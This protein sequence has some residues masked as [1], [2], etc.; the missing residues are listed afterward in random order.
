MKHARAVAFFLLAATVCRA[1]GDL[2][3]LAARLLVTPSR[4]P[5]E[6]ASVV[7]P[8]RDVGQTVWALQLAGRPQEAQAVAEFALRALDGAKNA[9]RPVGSLPPQVNSRGESSLPRCYVDAQ[10]VS[11]ALEA[12]WRL[13]SAMPAPARNAWLQEWWPRIAAAAEFVVGWTRGPRGEPY[14]AYDPGVNHDMGGAFESPG[15]LLGVVCAQNLAQLAGQ[16]VPE[17]WQQRREALEILVRTTDFTDATRATRPPWGLPN[18]RG[19]LPE[20]HPL[21]LAPTNSGDTIQS[22][23]IAAWPANRD[24]AQEIIALK[25]TPPTSSPPAETAGAPV[26]GDAP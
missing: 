7:I 2:G 9:G 3:S 15:A 19:I 14:P 17:T 1:E 11:A 20:E 13:A 8:L 6:S 22:A 12:A 5:A 25:V 18:L 24:T 4:V 21:W 23:R 26:A 10:A 16:A